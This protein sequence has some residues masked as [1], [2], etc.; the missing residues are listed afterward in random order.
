MGNLQEL[1][2]S[3]SDLGKRLASRRMIS[4]STTVSKGSATA[5][6]GEVREG[7]CYLKLYRSIVPSVSSP[8]IS[9]YSGYTNSTTMGAVVRLT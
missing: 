3:L 7:L 2:L 1:H 8:R 6:T 9:A 5:V 4:L